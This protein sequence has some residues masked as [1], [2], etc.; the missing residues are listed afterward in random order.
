M[1]KL[2]TELVLMI[3]TSSKYENTNCFQRH[4]LPKLFVTQH[5]HTTCS[6]VHR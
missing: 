4:M 1:V 5:S 2:E 3:T 6:E